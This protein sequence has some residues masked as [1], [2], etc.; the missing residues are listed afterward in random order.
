MGLVYIDGRAHVN[1]EAALKT[2]KELQQARRHRTD[3]PQKNLDHFAFPND[4]DP[5]TKTRIC[6]ED[7]CED[8]VSG[9]GKLCE[10]HSMERAERRRLKRGRRAL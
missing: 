4:I 9:R 1:R 5:V 3:L 8:W 2:V 10:Q 6:I 7:G